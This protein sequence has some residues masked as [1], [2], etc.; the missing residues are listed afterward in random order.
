[1]G[2]IGRFRPQ[3]GSVAGVGLVGEECVPVVLAKVAKPESSRLDFH[4][5]IPKARAWTEFRG[6]EHP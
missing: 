3:K 6:G 5:P 2:P 1:M 4:G